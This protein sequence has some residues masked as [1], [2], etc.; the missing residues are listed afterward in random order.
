MKWYKDSHSSRG[1]SVFMDQMKK[2][3]E[4]LE[5]AEE[6]EVIVHFAFPFRLAAIFFPL[7]RVFCFEFGCSALLG[8]KSQIRALEEVTLD[9]ISDQRVHPWLLAEDA[10]AID[11]VSVVERAS[12]LGLSVSTSQNV[13]RL[14]DQEYLSLTGTLED[15]WRRICR[16]QRID[17]ESA[18]KVW[19]RYE[20]CAFTRD[21]DNAAEFLLKIPDK[22][23]E[24]LVSKLISD[25]IG[26]ESKESLRTNRFITAIAQRQSLFCRMLEV[27]FKSWQQV[28]FE[29]RFF[30]EAIRP[31]LSA[32]HANAVGPA[33]LLYPEGC[34]ALAM[35]LFASENSDIDLEDRV[36]DKALT[37]AEKA[38]KTK[39]ANAAKFLLLSFPDSL[40]TLY[41]KSSEKGSPF[42]VR[43]LNYIACD[44]E[45]EISD[46][47]KVLT[48]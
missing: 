29:S 44:D 26:R 38:L 17:E 42:G 8:E 35:F 36:V 37:I 45:F 12:K 7:F 19:R 46:L 20:S 13:A 21:D 6:G 10:A 9:A 2:F 34:R 39:H 48:L 24:K 3:I 40:L 5:H 32:A 11:L 41:E 1:W 18:E 14:L 33:A 15:V 22:T 25:N 27:A 47:I 16:L 4:W 43:F 30:A 23:L 28:N 31:C